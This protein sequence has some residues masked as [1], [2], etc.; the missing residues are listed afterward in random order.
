MSFHV[1]VRSIL[2]ARSL[3][4]TVGALDQSQDSQCNHSAESIRVEVPPSRFQYTLLQAIRLRV[5]LG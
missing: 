1:K 4:A 3:K 2:K 5:V